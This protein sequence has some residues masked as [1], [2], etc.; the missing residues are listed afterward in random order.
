MNY[1]EQLKSPMWQ[2]KR[3]KIMERD[4]FSCKICGDNKNILNIHH[5]VYKN[6]ASAWEYTDSMLI[7]LCEKCHGLIHSIDSDFAVKFI[8]FTPNATRQMCFGS[9]YI[10]DMGL[11]LFNQHKDI[12]SLMFDYIEFG[13]IVF[14][15][16]STQRTYVLTD[17][18]FDKENNIVWI[19]S[20]FD[21]K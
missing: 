18:I 20:F 2:K 3:L 9:E 16:I 19:N 17:L 12:S 11:S 4:N 21:A 13:S 7:T 10:K 15:S 1:S 14:E 6:N 5:Y 8:R